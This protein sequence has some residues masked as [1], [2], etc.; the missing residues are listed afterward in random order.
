MPGMV[1]NRLDAAQRAFCLSLNELTYE[2]T[3]SAAYLRQ[4]I[5]LALVPIIAWRRIGTKPVSKPVPGYCQ[6]DN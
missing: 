2:L 4:W 6:L 3:P 5:E 1:E